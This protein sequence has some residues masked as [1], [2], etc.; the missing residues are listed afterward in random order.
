MSPMLHPILLAGNGLFLKALC[1]SQ[2]NQHFR[3]IGLNL[4]YIVVFVCFWF[5]LSFPFLSLLKT[6]TVLMLTLLQE[7]TFFPDSILI[8]KLRVGPIIKNNDT[9]V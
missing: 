3:L 5:F 7:P 1:G 2:C 4:S 9:F 6:H 8:L